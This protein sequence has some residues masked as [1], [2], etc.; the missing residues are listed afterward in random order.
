MVGYFVS[1]SYLKKCRTVTPPGLSVC[2]YLKVRVT[3]VFKPIYVVSVS[4]Q[5]ILAY[6]AKT[7]FSNKYRKAW[8]SVAFSM[9]LKFGQRLTLAKQ[10]RLWPFVN[11]P[12][13]PDVWP[14]LTL[15]LVLQAHS[16][17]SYCVINDLFSHKYKIWKC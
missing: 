15:C 10:W 8:K 7:K 4:I 17:Q 1:I 5:R 14:R 11:N 2:S 16:L 9:L 6:N 13:I 12:R 3:L